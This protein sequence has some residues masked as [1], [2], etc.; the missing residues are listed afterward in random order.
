MVGRAGFHGIELRHRV[1][2][3]HNGRGS[4]IFFEMLTLVVPG[5]NSVFEECLS[6]QANPTCSGVT[7]ILA[8]YRSPSFG[9]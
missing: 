7:F 5:I 9:R 4:H 3:E 1:F 8:A 6:S 2:I